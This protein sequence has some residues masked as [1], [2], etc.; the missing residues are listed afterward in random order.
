MKTLEDMYQSEGFQAWDSDNRSCGGCGIILRDPERFDRMYKAAE[1]GSEGSTHAE[2]IDA[3]NEYLE[4]I[5]GDIDE[6][7]YDNISNEII[8][9]WDWHDKNGSLDTEIG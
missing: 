2:I 4:L 8:Q 9:C 3:W 1:F 7:T 6:Q 5:S